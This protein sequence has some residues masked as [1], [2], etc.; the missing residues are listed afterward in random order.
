MPR[1]P[2]QI[3]TPQ[4]RWSIYPSLHDSVARLLAEHNLHFGFHPT[5]DAIS[6]TK[7]YDTNIMGKFTCHNR[8]CTSH[9]WSSKKIAI[10]IRGEYNG[11]VYHQRCKSCNTL[12]KPILDDSYTERIAYRIK[13]WNGIEMDR[14]VYSG[15]GKSNGPHNADLCEGCKEGRCGA[16]DGD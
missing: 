1:R 15:T 6:C 11:R 14:P 10:T 2:Y 9:G 5:D 12:S 7:E 3:S 16:F 8:A 4:N 13:K